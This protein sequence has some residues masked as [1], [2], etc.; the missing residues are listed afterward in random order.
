MHSSHF[1]AFGFTYGRI[2]SISPQPPSSARILLGLSTVGRHIRRYESRLAT[3]VA[4][5]VCRVPLAVISIFIRSR[6]RFSRVD[7]YR[8]K[9]KR[10]RSVEKCRRDRACPRARVSR[11][12]SRLSWVWREKAWVLPPLCVLPD[13]VTCSRELLEETN[14]SL[15]LEKLE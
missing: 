6:K 9:T 1:S 3:G 8:S 10:D 11:H 13:V 12:V 5:T 2:A 14:S 15:F 4:A 7:A